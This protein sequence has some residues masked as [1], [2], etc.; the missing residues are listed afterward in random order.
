MQFAGWLFRFA[1]FWFLLDA[2]SVGGSVRTCCSCSA[3][4]RSPARVPFTPG[5]AGVQQAL[6]RKVFAGRRRPRP[7]PP[8]RSGQQIAIAAFSARRGFV[9]LVFIFRF[10]SFKEVIRAGREHA[11]GRAA[12]AERT[13]S[14]ARGRAATAGPAG[15][16]HERDGLGEDRAITGGSARPAPRRCPGC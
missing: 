14:P 2:F 9:A 5:G 10:R 16:A 4:T 15:L 3:S 6:P 1:A 13:R 8:T 11:R 12:T 7:S